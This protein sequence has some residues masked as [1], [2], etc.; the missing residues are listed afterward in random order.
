MKRLPPILLIVF[1]VISFITNAFADFR[2]DTTFV[3]TTFITA[4]A[5]K[6]ED[7]SSKHITSLKRADLNAPPCQVSV[8]P[9]STNLV[10][11]NGTIA[12]TS[13]LV[14][15]DDLIYDFNGG[16]RKSTIVYQLNLGTGANYYFRYEITGNNNFIDGT[17]D[18]RQGTSGTWTTIPTSGS[19]DNGTGN[20][21]RTISFVNPVVISGAGNASNISLSIP[22]L[23]R[24]KRYGGPNGISLTEHRDVGGAVLG[25][26]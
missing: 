10:L 15:V 3:E 17:V 21:A 26:T 4:F 12:N 19:V 14:R 25:V 11:H 8:T 7:N 23:R 5:T 13:L 24:D 6:I 18:Y 1:F 16:N 22:G 9:T 20:N 2:K